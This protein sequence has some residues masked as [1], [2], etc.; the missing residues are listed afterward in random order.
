[1]KHLTSRPP[2]I[3]GYVLSEDEIAMLLGSIEIIDEALAQAPLYAVATPQGPIDM[4]ILTKDDMQAVREELEALNLALLQ[5][6][7][8]L[9]TP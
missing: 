6:K 8:V 1:M 2:E 7:A 5:C 4:H 9:E 3:A